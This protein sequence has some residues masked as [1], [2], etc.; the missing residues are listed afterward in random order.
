[1]KLILASASPRRAELLR[2]AGFD[3]EVLPVDVDESTRDGEPPADYVGR[4]AREKSLAAI[5]RRSDPN[6]LVIGAD[7][8]VIVDGTIL[9]KPQDDVEA[10]RMLR[11]LAGRTHEVMTGVSIRSRTDELMTVDVTTVAFAPLTDAEID[12]YVQSAEGRDKAGAY[13]IQGVASRFIDRIEGSYSN[14]VGLPVAAVYR[15]IRELD[16]RAAFLASP[17]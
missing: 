8:T 2:T 1:M 13:G 17:K 7:T 6:L 4:L 9:S 12:W 3:F 11:A 10:R 14:V 5:G 16:R 15:L